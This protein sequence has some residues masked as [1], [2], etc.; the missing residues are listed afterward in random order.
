[1]NQVLLVSDQAMPNFLPILNHDL[2][3]DSVTLVVS[4]KMCNRAE[5]LKNEIAKH[6]VAILADISIGSN[7]SDIN[8]IQNALMEWAGENGAVFSDSVLNVTGGTKPMAIAAQGV[9]Q[10]ENRPIFYVDIATDTIFWVSGDDRST[11]I[12]LTNQPTLNQFFGL[13]GIA[14]KAGEFKS[15][16][17][18]D[19]WRHFYHE[20]AGDPSKWALPLKALNSIASRAEH[21]RSLEFDPNEEEMSLPNW[22]EI[23]MLLRLNE[24]VRYENDGRRM[25]QF[26]S[27]EARSFFK[28]IWLEHYVFALLKSF[29]FDRRHALMNV[30]IEDSKGNVNEL[31][32]VV[33]HNNTCYIIEDKAK[34][35]SVGNIA[36]NAVYKL[37]QLS[38][39]MGLRA[40][41]ILVSVHNVR[42]S[43]K[44]RAR[45]Y[46]VEVFDWLPDLESNLGR[47]FGLQRRNNG[48]S[49]DMC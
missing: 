45:A 20:I 29:G 23:L 2:K 18:N 37:A 17:E 6:Q 30:I 5:W 19:K 27:I 24:L 40:K 36:D 38:S 25:G 42:R 3:P 16:I 26:S 10:L 41:G 12:Q 1:M 28:G 46:N 13:N 9:F 4:D 7:A 34:D 44:D 11:S 32:A 21:D 14:I 43:D 8:A 33:L 48:K 47:I 35:M 15:V 49:G 39:K 22:K 31:D